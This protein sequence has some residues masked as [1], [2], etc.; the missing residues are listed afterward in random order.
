HLGLGH[1]ARGVG[2]D[3]GAAEEMQDA[4]AA[5][6]AV[7]AHLDELVGAAL[8]PGRHHPAVAVPHRAEA[9]PH[10]GVAPHRP[11]LDEFADDALV[12][13]LG[14]GRHGV[15]NRRAEW[16]DRWRSALRH[17]AIETAQD[18]GAAAPYMSDLT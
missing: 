1:R 8:E 4:D 14:C 16:I 7:L 15:L 5:R 3:C 10:Q 17:P 11:V 18:A 12:L 9:I 13:D 6:I 2:V